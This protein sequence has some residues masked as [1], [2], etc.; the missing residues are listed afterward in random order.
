MSKTPSKDG[1]GR[2][3]ANPEQGSAEKPKQGTPANLDHKSQKNADEGWHTH[4]KRP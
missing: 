3:L 1:T 4:I 2:L